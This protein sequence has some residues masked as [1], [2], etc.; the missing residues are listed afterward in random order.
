MLHLNNVSCGYNHHCIIDDVTLRLKA[1]EVVCILGTNGVGKTT[2]FKSILGHIPLLRGSI[3]LHGTDLQQM[4]VTEKAQKI[5][6]VP[7]AHIPPFPFTVSDVVVMGRTSHLSAF[8]SPSK[9]DYEIAE[10]AL[11]SI[12]IAQ[13]KERIYTE[14]SGGERQMVLIARA[15]AQSPSLLI[16]DEPTSNLD[17]GNQTRTIQQV[18]RLADKGLGI[19]MTTHSPDHVYRCADKVLVI[20]NRNSV[21][22]GAVDEVLNDAL[23]SELYHIPVRSIIVEGTHTCVALDK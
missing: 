7:Q 13:L 6:Y 5:G 21:R 4:T 15:L 3:L 22:F 19:I 23:L 16:M 9:H 20:K 8:A 11:S 18:R 10:Q 14:L 2:L 17:Y 12:G 1:G